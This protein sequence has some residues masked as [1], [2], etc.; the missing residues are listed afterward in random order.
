MGNVI[1]V[2][3]HWLPSR[4]IEALRRAVPHLPHMF[5]RAASMPAMVDPGA[6]FAVMDVFEGYVQIPSLASPPV[7]VLAPGSL[8]VDLVCVANDAQ[9]EV[10]ARHEGRFLSFVASV[11]MGKGDRAVKEARRS[12]RQLDAAGVQIYTSIGS[13]PIDGPEMLDLFA[14]MAELDRPIWLH[15]IRGMNHA[16]YPTEWVSKYDIWWAFGWP[17]ETGAAMAR[18]VFSGVFDRWPS[19]KVIT[20]HAGGIVPMIEGRLTSGMEMLGPQQP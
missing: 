5:E 6:R 3:C 14:A 11:P 18:V 8:I 1:D 13:A 15:P 16:D 17:Y 4:Y 12:V 2:F 19:L 9:A 7:E 20:H 10:V